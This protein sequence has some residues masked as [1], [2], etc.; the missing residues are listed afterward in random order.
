MA[1]SM[2]KHVKEFSAQ[3][4]QLWAEAKPKALRL[5]HQAMDMFAETLF[6]KEKLRSAWPE[7]LSTCHT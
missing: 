3:R 4:K 1:R 7:F 5:R 2:V 6:L